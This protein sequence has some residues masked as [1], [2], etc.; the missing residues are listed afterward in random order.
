MTAPIAFGYTFPAIRGIQANNEYY[1]VMCPLKYVQRLFVFVEEELAPEYRDQ[2]PLNTKRVPQISKYML[3]KRNEYVFSSL[4]ACIS[5]DTSF[6]PVG[7]DPHSKD[8]GTLHI[9]ISAQ[10]FITDG[11]HRKAAIEKAL[12]EDPSLE[13]ESISVVF[14]VNRDLRRRQVMFRDLNQ[15]QVK[16]DPSLSKTFGDS[17][18]DLLSQYIANNSKTFKGLIEMGSTNLAPRSVKLF[19]HNA[20]QNANIDL[21][22]KI[23]KTELAQSKKVCKEYWDCIGQNIPQW[24]QLRNNKVTSRDLRMYYIHSHAVTLR[25]LGY[26]GQYLL[27]NEPNWKSVLKGLSQINW[28]R[29]NGIDWEGR[30]INSARMKMSKLSIV[31]TASLI[32]QKL[33]IPLTALEI[34]EEEKFLKANSNG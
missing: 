14:F 13:D 21:I 29:S 26:I 10:C 3:D 16:T 27:A 2:R 34:R 15:Y 28:E 7:N 22:G 11:Q 18:N 30:C 6:V 32:K 25:A 1:S 23:S 5:G 4:T 17:P 24:Q 33:N 8:I 31:L 9:D 19:S 12:L 20:L